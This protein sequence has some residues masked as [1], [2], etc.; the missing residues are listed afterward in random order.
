MGMIA[1]VAYVENGTAEPKTP[2]LEAQES[3]GADRVPRMRRLMAPVNAGVNAARHVL[4]YLSYHAQGPK[5]PQ[6]R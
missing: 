3:A 5:G 6:A 4:W 1:S 2:V